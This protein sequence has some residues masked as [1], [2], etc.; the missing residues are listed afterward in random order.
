MLWGPAEV[1]PV[2]QNYDRPEASFDPVKGI[3]T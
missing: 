1:M 2:S 3:C